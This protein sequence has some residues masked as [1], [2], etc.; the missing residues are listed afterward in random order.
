MN[1]ITFITLIFTAIFA[2]FGCSDKDKFN[3]SHPDKGGINLIMDWSNIKSDIPSK[4]KAYIVYESGKD[5]LFNN[6][7]GTSNNLIVEPGKMKNFHPQ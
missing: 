7:S 1:K 3:T 4:Y 2:L 6:L 5:T